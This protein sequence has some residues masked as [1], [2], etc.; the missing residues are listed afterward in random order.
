M[1]NEDSFLKPFWLGY[2]SIHAPSAVEQLSLFLEKIA[3]FRPDLVEKSI[4]AGRAHDTIA[5]E[6]I[7]REVIKFSKQLVKDGIIHA[8]EC[9][10]LSNLRFNHTTNS[11]HVGY[12][13]RH[14]EIKF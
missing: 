5:I 12:G 11:V 4:E 8:D 13:K 3:E 9:P 14:F 1:G 10:L 7:L 6:T 2:A